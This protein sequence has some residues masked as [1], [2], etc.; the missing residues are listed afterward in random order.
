MDPANSVSSWASWVAR[1]ASRAR[2]AAVSTSTAILTATASRTTTVTAW[3]GLVTTKECRGSVRNHINNAAD[4]KADI[5]AGATPPNSATP[6]TPTKKTAVFA[7]TS[8]TA[9]SQVA[10]RPQRI[11]GTAIAASQDAIR[12][13]RGEIEDNEN[14]SCACSW[15]TMCTSILPDRLM[16]LVPIPSRN[17]LAHRDR[18]EV[19]STN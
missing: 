18:R 1:F 3:L 9:S 17:M 12:R 13:P 15:V 5:S 19:P 4:I 10:V 2:V 11:Q 14:P 6:I 16:V 8:R 7:P